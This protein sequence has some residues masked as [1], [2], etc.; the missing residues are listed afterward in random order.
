M[1]RRM[2]WSSY[3]SGLCLLATAAGAQAPATKA[4]AGAQ[5]KEDPFSHFH[6]LSAGGENRG[7]VFESRKLESL[8][9]ATENLP[10][11]VQTEIARPSSNSMRIT[12][13]VFDVDANGSRQ[14]VEVVVEDLRTTTGNGV[15]ATRTISRRD[16]N[17]NLQVALKQTQETTPAGTDTYKTQTTTQA[18][19]GG[20]N[21]VRS[22]EITQ[23]EKK[24]A[25]GAIEID[26]T[27]MMPDLNGRWSTAD[28]RVSSTRDV[29]GQIVTQADDYKPD[30]NGKLSLTQRET[31]RE[32]KDPQG[33]ERQDSDIQTVSPEGNLQLSGRSSIVRVSFPDGSGE[34]TQTL[35]SKSPVTPSEGLK[36][37]EKIVETSRP[38]DSRTVQ[39]ETTVQTPDANG[40]LQTLGYSKVIENK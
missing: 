7:L 22:E 30:L 15:S 33:R 26:R 14:L 13:R 12:R 31:S 17:G 5:E 24:A 11:E 8:K 6:W 20:G 23:V 38:A 19:R 36:L 32:W 2:L 1:I 34:T 4:A 16:A 10:A 9:P 35:Y 3:L 37:L 25:N 39:K 27:Q 40:K 28:R 29:K 18:S 21:L